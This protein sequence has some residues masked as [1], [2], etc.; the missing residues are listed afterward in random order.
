MD[1]KNNELIVSNTG[2][3]K[4]AQPASDTITVP[5]AQLQLLIQ[6][7][8]KNKDDNAQLLSMLNSSVEMLSFVK[9]TILGG[10]MPTDMNIGSIIKLAT[11]IPRILNKLDEETINNLSDNFKNIMDCAGQF[12]SDEQIQ[13]ISK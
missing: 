1:D 5:K 11:K 13:K 3:A 9:N 7:N 10:K 2:D 8:K 6:Q 12:L 4:N